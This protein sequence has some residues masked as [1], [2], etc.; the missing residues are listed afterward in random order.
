IQN[1]TSQQTSSNFNISGNGLIG[2]NFGIGTPTLSARLAV[3]GDG[4]DVLIG[5]AG[6]G[7]PTAAIGFG[8]MSGCND[9]ALGGDVSNTGNAGIYLNRPTGRGI[10]FRENNTADQL[11][12]APGGNVGIGTST[13]SGLLHVRGAS[14]VRILGDPTTLSGIESVDFF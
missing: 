12:I 1:T 2:G 4:T 13:P 9:F 10:H 7:P 11:T 14:P 5:S 6:C 8:A 3:R